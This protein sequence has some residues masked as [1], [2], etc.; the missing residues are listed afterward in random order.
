MEPDAHMRAERKTNLPATAVLRGLVMEARP[1]A[2]VRPARV[3]LVI[4]AAKAQPAALEPEPE[5][6]SSDYEQAFANGRV[7][8]YAAG[9][10]AAVE[11]AH[12]LL[13]ASMGASRAAAAEEGRIEGLRDGRAQAQVELKLAQGN[14]VDAAQ[15]AVAQR[16]ERLD[17]LLR[18]VVAETEHWVA[19]AEDDLVALGHDAICRILGSEAADPAVIRAMVT[20]LLAEHGQRE[21]LVV[22]VHPEDFDTLL[23]HAAGAEKWRWVS[24]N[25]V[26]IGGVILRSPDG[27]L[28][29]RLENQLASLREALLTVRLERRAAARNVAATSMAV[30]QK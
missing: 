4:A 22:H 6:K 15:L 28:D 27:S 30:A 20:H 23:P 25:S 10:H 17:Q 3:G 11:E 2:L 26:Q 12:Q 13:Q 16:L 5:P 19:G 7:E 9:R 1:H 24:D 8:G 14:A 21:H 29:A 18:S